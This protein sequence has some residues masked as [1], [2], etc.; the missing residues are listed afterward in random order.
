MDVI[1]LTDIKCNNNRICQTFQKKKKKNK[2][3]P[4]AKFLFWSQ[5]EN[6]Y[7]DI[8]ISCL[9]KHKLVNT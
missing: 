8:G 1:K 2:T 4:G 6:I 3:I 5:T 9:C 7:T